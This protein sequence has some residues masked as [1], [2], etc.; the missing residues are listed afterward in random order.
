MV[1]MPLHIQHAS[2]PP[3]ARQRV[4]NLFTHHASTL[5]ACD[6]QQHVTQASSVCCSHLGPQGCL[7]GIGR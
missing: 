5:S 7:R 6:R 3:S 2:L 1:T 4:S